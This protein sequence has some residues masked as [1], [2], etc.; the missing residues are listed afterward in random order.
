MRGYGS[1]Q[2]TLP[3]VVEYASPRTASCTNGCCVCS[4]ILD[5]GVA[6][7]RLLA[8]GG[9][10]HNRLRIAVQRALRRRP[11]M[12]YVFDRH[13]GELRYITPDVAAV[14]VELLSLR[15]GIEDPDIRCRVGAAA[16]HP[17]PIELV[18]RDVSV[19]QMLHEPASAMPPSEVQILDQE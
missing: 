17:L 12:V 7:Q 19:A 13:L 9:V 5:D 8:L 11:G 4:K 10:N 6:V 16:G 1:G 14:G 3:N 15:G 2:R 18:L